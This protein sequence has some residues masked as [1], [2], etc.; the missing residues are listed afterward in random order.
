MSEVSLLPDDSPSL[1]RGLFRRIVDWYRPTVGYLFAIDSHVYAMSIAASVL[2]GFF[3]FLVLIL[4]VSRNVLEWP[5][6]EAAIY[7]GLRGFL[8]ED[9]GLVGFVERNVRFAVLSRGRVE[10]VS[11]VLLIFS[12]NG[13]F[14]PLEVALN[15][16]WR[17]PGDRSYWRNQ[18][19]SF[20]LTFLC[21]AA[22]VGSAQ[23]AA[24]NLE[25]L[26]GWFPQADQALAAGLKLAEISALIL[27]FTLIYWRLPNGPAPLRRVIPTAIFAAAAVET[28]QLVYATIWPL[29]DLRGAY[30]PFFISITLLLWGFFSAMIVLAGAEMCSRPARI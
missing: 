14:M 25:R 3:P 12:A 10:A 16:L 9:P 4:S 24:L 17:F 6:A 19:M 28:G 15:R 23:L 2:L 11:I 20:S 26:Q 21:G 27:V 29:L 7:V 8:P 13:V 22:A 5:G 18:L 30:G 1:S